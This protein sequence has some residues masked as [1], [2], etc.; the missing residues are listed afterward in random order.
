MD[1]LTYQDFSNHKYSGNC[2]L[3]TEDSCVFCEAYYAQQRETGAGWN[4]VEEFLK[5][6][7]AMILGINV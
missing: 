2:T 7:T 1:K 3:D 5:E 4:R 6:D